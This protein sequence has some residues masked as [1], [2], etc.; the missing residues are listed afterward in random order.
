M[1]VLHFL[2]LWVYLKTLNIWKWLRWSI[3]YYVYFITI[4]KLGKK[5]KN[6]Y[7][8]KVYPHHWIRLIGKKEREWFAILILKEDIFQC[9]CDLRI[10]VTIEIWV[11][12]ENK[13]PKNTG[14]KLIN[15]TYPKLLSSSKN[16]QANNEVIKI[17]MR[18]PFKKTKQLEPAVP[19]FW[20][21]VKD[22]YIYTQKW[23]F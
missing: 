13:W 12:H 18:Q 9:A 1:V 2:K 22:T 8:G 3:L 10:D 16:N 19:L 20:E 11:T 17:T 5:I 15:K 14:R 4:K 23:I 6:I 21:H 7:P